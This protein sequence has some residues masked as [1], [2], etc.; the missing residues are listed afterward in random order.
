VAA[1]IA[2]TMQGTSKGVYIRVLINR[3]FLALK[4]ALSF[5]IDSLASNAV[6]LIGIAGSGQFW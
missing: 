3:S 4:G 6:N 2:A 5:P 1:K